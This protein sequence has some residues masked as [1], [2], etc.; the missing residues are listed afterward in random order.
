[1]VGKSPDDG[2]LSLLSTCLASELNLEKRN[3]MTSLSFSVFD[4]VDARNDVDVGVTSVLTSVLTTSKRAS[5][6]KNW[7]DSPE[8]VSHGNGTTWR[9]LELVKL[10]GLRKSN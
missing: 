7:F 10:K 5:D 1:M 4:K 8:L 6:V 3:L 9:E 2:R